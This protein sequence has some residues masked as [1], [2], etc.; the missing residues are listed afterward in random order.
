[1]TQLFFVGS[2]DFGCFTCQKANMIDLIQ[3]SKQQCCKIHQ[4]I[5]VSSCSV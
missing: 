2:V 4:F 3:N 5:F 1:M